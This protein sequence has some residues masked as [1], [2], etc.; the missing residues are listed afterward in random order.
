MFARGGAKPILISFGLMVFLALF[1]FVFLSISI[2]PIFGLILFLFTLYFFRDPDREVSE[3]ITS[4]ADGMIQDIDHDK[5][6]IQIFMNIWNVHVNRSPWSG[7][8]EKMEHYDGGHS[9]AYKD[10]AKNN[11]RQLLVLST[12]KGEI[13]IWQIAGITARRIVPY[14]EKGDLID[15]GERI[16]IVRFGSKVKLEFEN[17]ID[18][19][20][21]EGQK[22]KAGK[23][24]LGEWNE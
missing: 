17:K 8:I 4:P 19:V 14:V 1:Y 11:E 18:F 2:L 22:V 5:N 20:V 9:P 21:E 23:T 6:E 10:E 13:N 7:T 3:G 24:S 16:G 15:K 12:D